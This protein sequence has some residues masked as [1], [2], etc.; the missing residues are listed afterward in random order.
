MPEQK[1]WYKTTHRWAQ[2]NF[3]ED[4]PKAC[5]LEFWKD[6]WVRSKI[7]GVIINCGGI[8][9]YYPSKIKSQ[10]RADTLGDGDFFLKVSTAARE[11]GLKVIARMDCSSAKEDFYNEHP[12]WFGRNKDGSPIVWNGLYRSCVNT[13][14]YKEYIPSILT[15]II[16]T[17]HPDGIADNSWKGLDKNQICYCD[18]CKKLFWEDCRLA[19]P[20]NPSWDDPAYPAW[21]EWGY[22]LRS[23]LW[24]RF[25]QIARGAGGEDCKWCGMLAASMTTE[26]LYDLKEIY[27]KSDIIFCDHQSRDYMAGFEQNSTIGAML[28]LASGENV[29]VTQSMAH[30]PRRDKNFRLSASPKA[31]VRAWMLEGI[32]GG[33]APW[34]H[35]V[36]GGQNDKR[37]FET[38]PELL[39]WHADCEQYLFDRVDLA[40]VAMVWSRK[41]V[42]Y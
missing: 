37:Q 10:Y 32:A 7:Q 13:D 34:V 16:E 25:S 1:P 35:H 8:V 23:R 30:Y 22:R 15:E 2:T 40:S 21:V 6:Y 3:T 26:Y 19:L 38:S 36:G 31:E 18:S 9:A 27:A 20:E 17:Y 14:Y 33:I 5:D 39:N 42:D 41:N 11:I 12:D 29:V 28:R 4:D 24:D